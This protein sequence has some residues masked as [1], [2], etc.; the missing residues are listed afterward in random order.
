MNKR[1]L[2]IAGAMFLIGATLL[3][4]GFIIEP[5]LVSHSNSEAINETIELDSF[6][7]INIDTIAT[8][9]QIEYG[10]KYSISYALSS[11]ETLK[12][13]E[14]KN[15]TLYFETK[16]SAFFGIPFSDS[17]LVLT[18]PYDTKIDNLNLK[19]VS[20]DIEISNINS[21]NL[22]IKATSSDIDILGNYQ[23]IDLKST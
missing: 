4:I 14:V 2:T 20:G 7:N 17:Y 9:V 11:K 21:N 18:I 5:N 8:D 15:D 19:T 22:K 3:G 10:E 6:K 16:I 12:N 1:I 23:K 13:I